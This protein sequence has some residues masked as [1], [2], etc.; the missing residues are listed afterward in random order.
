MN[1]HEVVMLAMRWLHLVGA[2]VLV[3]APIFMWLVLEPAMAQIDSGIRDAM[4]NRIMRGWRMFLGLVILTQIVSGFYWLFEVVHIA[5]Q[6]PVYQML[7]G[8]KMLA[9]FVLFF[10]LSVLA[11]R[12]KSFEIFR[13]QSRRW[14]G[15]A[16]IT[17]LL[18]VFCASA[19]RISDAQRHHVELP[20]APGV[21]SPALA[22]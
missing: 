3:G 17:A 11:G 19:M 6:P 5:H 21:V 7:L 12:A 4:Q 13:R 8:V 18:V 10:L 14:L 22:K 2:C 15:V 1:V 9:A 20:T 16:A